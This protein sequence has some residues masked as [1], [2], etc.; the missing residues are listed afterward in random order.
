V[1]IRFGFKTGFLDLFHIDFWISDFMS[2][3]KKTHVVFVLS[4]EFIF[5]L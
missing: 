1:I 4:V 3:P 2:T 5:W